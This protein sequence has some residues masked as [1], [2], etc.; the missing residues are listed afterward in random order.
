MHQRISLYLIVLLG[1]A[2]VAGPAI[3]ADDLGT[4]LP[5]PPNELRT[6]TSQQII[7][8][9][10]G[11]FTFIQI[12]DEHSTPPNY[13]NPGSYGFGIYSWFDQDYGWMHTFPFWNN[14]DLL[15]NEATLTIV[16]WDV[17]SEPSHG[18]DGEYDGIHVDG[19]LLDP[20]YL[21]GTNATWSVTTFNI[22]MSSI[23]DD[24]DIDVW[25]D[26]D[27][28]HNED[29]WATTL[30]YCELRITY[31]LSET[32][33][34]PFEPDLVVTP[35]CPADDD[36]LTVQ[37]VGPIPPDPN[38]DAVTYQF[39]WF[40]DVGTGQYIEDA[41]AGRG[42]HD[43]ASVPAADTVVGDLWRVQVRSVDEH[44]VVGN[45]STVTWSEPIGCLESD[46]VILDAIPSSLGI[47]VVNQSIDPESVA[48][49]GIERDHCVTDGTSRLFLRY[50]TDRPGTLNVQL[51][52]VLHPG[53]P[54][55]SLVP[56]NSTFEGTAV[57]THTYTTSEGSQAF[58]VYSPPGSL[59]NSQDYDDDSRT[60]RLYLIFDP[61]DGSP[62]RELL[63]HIYLHR[64]PI[65]FVHGIWS[66][67]DAWIE[68]G[69]YGDMARRLGVGSY[70]VNY[71]GQTHVGFN[72]LYPRVKQASLDWISSYQRR[73]IACSQVQVVAHSMGG[74][75]TRTWMREPN[76]YSAENY[77]EGSVDMLLTINTPHHGSAFANFY[78]SKN[79]F[80]G[81]LCFNAMNCIKPYGDSVRNMET[82]SPAIMA[83][84]QSRTQVHAFVGTGGTIS[85]ALAH[86]ATRWIGILPVGVLPCFWNLNPLMI[87]GFEQHDYIVQRSSQEGGLNSGLTTNG[88]IAGEHTEAPSQSVIAAEVERLLE[89]GD[90]SNSLVSSGFPAPSGVSAVLAGSSA[91]AEPG[92]GLV[93][94]DPA[95]VNR[96]GEVVILSP[97]TG[98]LWA[99]GAAVPIQVDFGQPVSSSIVMIGDEIFLELDPATGEA[100]W[101]PE[102]GTVGV[103]AIKVVAVGEDDVISSISHD[104]TIHQST[105][106]AA[107]ALETSRI[108]VR[109]PGE[110]SRILL[111]GMTSSG[112]HVVASSGSLGTTYT[113][114][115]PSIAQVDQNGVVTAAGPGI[116]NITV[117]NAAGFEEDVVFEVLYAV[118]NEPPVADIGGPYEVCVGETLCLDGTASHDIDGTPTENLG[119]EWDLD[120]DGHFDEATGSNPC[121]SLLSAGQLT[122]SLKVTDNSGAQDVA[123]T[124]LTGLACGPVIDGVD[125]A[126]PVPG[127]ELEIIG[128]LFGLDPGPGARS[129]DAHNVALSGHRLADAD[130]LSWEEHSIVVRLPL[131]AMSGELVVTVDYE[132]SNPY[133]L[134]IVGNVT[135]C[136]WADATS[137]PLGDTIDGHGVSWGD[138]DGDGDDDLFLANNGPNRLLRNDGDGDYVKLDV[139]LG[140]E[141][142]SRAGCWG[143][144]DNDGDL[145]LY[146][147]N[148]GA[149][150]AL[151]RNDGGEFTDVTEGPLGDPGQNTSGV[152]ADWDLDG[153]VDLYLT[154][155]D[156]RSKLLRND[157]GTFTDLVGDP[158]SFV[159]WSRGCAFGDYDN[160]GDPD[161]YVTI[162][163]GP[164]KLFRNDRAAGF[165]DVSASPVDFSASCKGC[166][167][168]DYDNDGWLDLYVV[169]KDGANRLFHNDAGVFT[170]VTDAVTGDEG[171]GRTCLWGDYDNDGWMDL[172]VTNVDGTNKL[173][174]N[175]HNGSF[176]DS[177]CGDLAAIAMTPWGAAFA[178]DDRDGDLDLYVSNHSWQGVPNRMFRNGLAGGQWLQVKLSGTTS[179]RFGLGARVELVADGQT[180]VRQVAP[181]GYL[182]Q[183]PTT[184]HFGLGDAHEATLRVIW[185]SGV[186]QEVPVT[187]VNMILEV[188]EAATTGV[189]TPANDFVFRI[190]NHPNPFNP[191]TT[192]SFSL[193]EPATVRLA[194]FDVGG[195]LVKTLL[196]GD[197]KGVGDHH[198]E[199]NGRTDDGATAPSGLY[200]FRVIAGDHQATR[201]MTLLK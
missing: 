180:Q 138:Y 161:L 54:L 196:D 167:W 15:I 159:G 147:V 67:S 99:E 142:D 45:Y 65:I 190:G 94:V 141:G 169:N 23:I 20:G 55:G 71:E 31:T 198:V 8:N 187:S 63:D 59:F 182:V 43:G 12:I 145:D 193:P 70:Y 166:A 77:N 57:A 119:F 98:S 17:D 116:T 108:V 96:T 136:L 112:K 92:A 132:T 151:Y 155:D 22:Q 25:C 131:T 135:G 194:I 6:P 189:E 181:S 115:N 118:P 28:H 106:F 128:R 78:S 73:G 101:T 174:R 150:N 90:V 183:S 40:V 52:D 84:G 76:F 139:S 47:S 29:H 13:T 32:N 83:L 130:V 200:F 9:P 122:I 156:G 191:S 144:Y 121:V 82:F 7:N 93:F 192:I 24:G 51:Q 44:G 168:G 56:L 11:S 48:V 179:N 201:S 170:D 1:L 103:F 16:A 14:P 107:L 30:D 35:A 2:A 41:F 68:A 143:D 140:G 87:F 39:E 113:V 162:K 165:A 74:L 86:G 18:Y 186:Y 164:N 185:P 49:G 75:L 53:Q 171:D 100:S 69:Y 79:N 137:G 80:L 163:D 91:P 62:D 42:E 146:V 178:D 154:C 27:M 72:A 114:A 61:D 3:A 85:F 21:Q 157:G 109:R 5:P 148:Y 37:I 123:T 34:A 176:A 120:G 124:T 184:C 173:F 66:S 117:R 97:A 195:R 95:A 88:G 133:L 58:V 129:T 64:P 46:L 199:W 60:I 50:S 102:P 188:V 89:L 126:S 4:I 153:D 160:D 81:R 125:P 149:A 177:T 36:N 111:S 19:T 104:F 152:W 38:G 158:A 105:P 197:V 26:I 127:G 172:F 110:K 10:D 175:L 134:D 33:S